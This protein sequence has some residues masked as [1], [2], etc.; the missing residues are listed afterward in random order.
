MGCSIRFFITLQ[1]HVVH[2]L[3][4][5]MPHYNAMEATKAVKPILGDYYGFDGTPIYKALWRET[6]ECLYVEP[7]DEDAPNSK[8]VYWYRNKF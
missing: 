4:S 2:H 5:T 6:K 1:T 3:F 7:D 8:S